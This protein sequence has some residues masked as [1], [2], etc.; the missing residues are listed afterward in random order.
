VI[1]KYKALQSQEQIAGLFFIEL[2]AGAYCIRPQILDFFRPGRMQ[3]APDESIPY[4]WR[5]E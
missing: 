3:Y 1:K 2:M 5:R 4:S